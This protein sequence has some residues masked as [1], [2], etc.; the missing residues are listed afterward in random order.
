VPWPAVPPDRRRAGAVVT[1]PTWC[2]GY[3]GQA[4]AT[5]GRGG[6]SATARDVDEHARPFELAS[7]VP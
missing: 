7:G 1:E 2:L 5:R 4:F 3:H 6:R